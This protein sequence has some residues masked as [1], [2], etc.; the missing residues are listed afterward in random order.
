M[1]KIIHLTI[2]NNGDYFSVKIMNEKHLKFL[3]IHSLLGNFYI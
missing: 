2:D 3:T 1:C